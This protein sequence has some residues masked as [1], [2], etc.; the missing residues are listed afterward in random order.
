VKYSKILLLLFTSSI[1]TNYS[2]VQSMQSP[3][4]EQTPAVF[5]FYGKPIDGPSEHTINTQD[6]SYFKVLTFTPE[7]AKLL[8]SWP[9]AL[10]TPMES[11]LP[12]YKETEHFAFYCQPA[13]EAIADTILEQFETY[14]KQLSI[15]FKRV[16]NTK[17][18]FKIYPN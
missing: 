17:M 9:Q 6:D 13:D 14:L 8:R 11:E 12:L 16:F 15:D 3:Q 4:D 7:E 10:E 1:L 5:E 2:D 18:T